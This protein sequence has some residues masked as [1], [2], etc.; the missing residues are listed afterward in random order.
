MTSFRGKEIDF[1]SG[2][3]FLI[4][5]RA[6]ELLLLL[7]P[8]ASRDNRTFEHEQERSNGMRRGSRSGMRRQ[9]ASTHNKVFESIKISFCF[10]VFPLA[11]LTAR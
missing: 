7:L 8:C 9:A 4:L 5:L 11:R 2:V 1:L 10:A 3:A 6:L